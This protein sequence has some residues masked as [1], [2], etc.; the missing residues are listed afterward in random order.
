MT[1][2]LSAACS[3]D[4]GSSVEPLTPARLA[5]VPADEYAFPAEWAGDHTFRWSAPDAIDLM[6]PEATVVRALAE[7]KRLSLAVGDRLAYPG[8]SAAVSDV[9]ELHVPDGGAYPVGAREGTWTYRWRGTFLA[10]ILRIDP[11]AQGFTAAYCVDFG[12]VAES[13]NGGRTYHWRSVGEGGK[14]DHGWVTWLR[15]TSNSDT[16]RVADSIGLDGGQTSRVPRFDPFH[17]WSV[18]EAW[19]PSPRRASDAATVDGC[20]QWTRSNP[21]EASSASD[22][23][24]TLAEPQDPYPGWPATG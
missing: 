15:V 19:G 1:V 3:A 8:Y 13:D 17:G 6:S 9:V 4:G 23:A 22:A 5:A 2:L 24:V 20:A 14:L 10:R 11:D 12:N 16:T 18:A 21:H 7:S